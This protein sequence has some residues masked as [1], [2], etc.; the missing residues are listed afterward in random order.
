MGEEYE[1][2]SSQRPGRKLTGGAMGRDAWWLVTGQEI[3]SGF[4]PEVSLSVLKFL[5][6][7]G[8]CESLHCMSSGST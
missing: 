2:E 6:P 8:S 1:G 3:D 7:D 5:V 4:W